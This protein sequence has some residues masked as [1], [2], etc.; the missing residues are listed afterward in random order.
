[1]FCKTA[2]DK[3]KKNPRKKA[4]KQNSKRKGIDFSFPPAR[5]RGKEKLLEK[6]KI[7][8][9]ENKESG[10]RLPFRR[11]VVPKKETSQR[12]GEKKPR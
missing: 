1:V 12:G 2:G 4:I 3:K 5:S 10:G 6:K 8:K 9:L 11:E 7:K